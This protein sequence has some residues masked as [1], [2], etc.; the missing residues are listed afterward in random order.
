MATHP[1]IIEVTDGNFT[2][3]PCNVLVDPGDTIEWKCEAGDFSVH[4]G[5]NT[6][7]EK[8]RYRSRKGVAVSGRVRP[9]TRGQYKYFV[10][11]HMNGET[12]TDD[13]TIIVKG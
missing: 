2:Y 7:C 9:G 5:W 3:K 8:G 1:V 12:W 11:V 13:P 6:P 10:A 4:L